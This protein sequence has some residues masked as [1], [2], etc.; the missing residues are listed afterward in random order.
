MRS[1]TPA[2]VTLPKETFHDLGA[3]NRL[4]HRLVEGEPAGVG[5]GA[6]ER[7]PEQG[8]DLL[9]RPVLPV[10][11]VN[12]REDRARRVGAQRRDQPRVR[13]RHLG[14]DT[15]LLQRV[16]QPVAG[17]QRHLPLGGQPAGQDEHVVQVAHFIASLAGAPLGRAGGAPGSS[18]GGRSSAPGHR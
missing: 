16:P 4:G 13:V 7:Y 17:A 3:G 8:Q 9:D 6:D 1:R 2:S 18:A 14:L 5:G 11:A 15:S 12:G 10:S